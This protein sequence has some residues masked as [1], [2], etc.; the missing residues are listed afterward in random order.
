MRKIKA[1]TLSV[2]LTLPKMT[3]RR[4]LVHSNS[5]RYAHVYKS[6]HN[7]MYVIIPFSCQLDMLERENLD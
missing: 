7:L 3:A 1:K 2:T 6:N 4:L 5:E